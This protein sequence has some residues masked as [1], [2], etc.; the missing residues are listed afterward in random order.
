MKITLTIQSS[1]STK[2]W[3]IVINSARKWSG[4]TK[5]DLSYWI[6]H[7]QLHDDETIQSISASDYEINT[8]VPSFYGIWIRIINIK[9]ITKLT[10]DNL[11]HCVETSLFIIQKTKKNKHNCSIESAKFTQTLNFV[12]SLVLKLCISNQIV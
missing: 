9:T 10:K 4:A 6:R 11:S 8:S 3:P 2:T 7:L 1:T 5:M 12:S